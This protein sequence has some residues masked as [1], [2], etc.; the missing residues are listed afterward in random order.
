MHVCEQ[1]RGRERERGR[2]RTPS[3]FHAVSTEPNVGLHLRNHEIMTRPETKS[4]KLKRLSHPGTSG[5]FQTVKSPTKSAN[6]NAK[7]MAPNIPQEGY[8]FRV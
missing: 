3:R 8:L 5:P 4:Q 1:W 7:H 2:E 6:K